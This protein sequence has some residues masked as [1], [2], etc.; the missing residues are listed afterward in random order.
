MCAWCVYVFGLVRW[1]VC[2]CVVCVCVFGVRQVCVRVCVQQHAQCFAAVPCQ[3]AFLAHVMCMCVCGC[4]CVCVRRIF[5]TCACTCTHTYTC[6]CVCVC[7]CVRG[8]FLL[9]CERV[10]ALVPSRA[11]SLSLYEFFSRVLPHP[12][13]SLDRMHMCCF[14]SLA[15]TQT[16]A[17]V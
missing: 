7:V 3:V 1:Y 13:L 4:G 10:F 17:C 8:C 14:L 11:R 15:P 6:V 5:C 16:Y 12:P 2:V 9:F